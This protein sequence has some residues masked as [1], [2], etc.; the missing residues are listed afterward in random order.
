MKT[1]FVL[2]V[3]VLVP[4][5]GFSQPYLS[6]M[7]GY[8]ST[9]LTL[10]APYNGVI[11]DYSAAL[12]LDIGFSF[13]RRWAVEAGA[14]RYDSFAGR[15]TPCV[16]GDVCILVIRPIRGNDMTLYRAALVPR[17]GTGNLRL[18]G[19]LGYYRANIEANIDLPGS[20]F[21]EDGLLVGA[22]LR[23]YFADP[24]SVSFEASRFDDNVQQLALGFGWGLRP[25]ED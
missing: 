8:A 17:F 9:N 5:A 12:G 21:H 13:G 7:V 23:W 6:A 24:W 22:G 11:D 15:G 25:L 3:S 18:F 4:A 1:P 16:E 10:D 19:R 20:D 2:L 14:V